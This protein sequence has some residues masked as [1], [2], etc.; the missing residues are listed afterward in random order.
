MSRTYGFRRAMVAVHRAG[1]AAALVTGVAGC[2]LMA[3]DL[4]G[5]WVLAI[6]FTVAVLVATVAAALAGDAGQTLPASPGFDSFNPSTGLPYDASLGIDM[7]GRPW[8]GVPED[9][10]R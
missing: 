9:I 3:F 2:V 7:S 6:A 4:P 1:L 5:H 8:R 10:R